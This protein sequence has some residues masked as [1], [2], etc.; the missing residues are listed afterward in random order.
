MSPEFHASMPACTTCTFSCDIARTVS[1]YGGAV[2]S[3]AT[4]CR[5]PESALAGAAVAP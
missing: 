3:P 5:L 4:I 2:N 1:P